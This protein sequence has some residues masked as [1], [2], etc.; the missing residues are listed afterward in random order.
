MNDANDKA[1]WTVPQLWEGGTCWIIGGGL[2]APRQFDVPEDIIMRVAVKRDL[3]P[4]AYSPY[5]QPIHNER[6]IAINNAYRIGTW[7]DA[8]F[9]G[10]CSWYLVHRRKL[11]DWPGIKATCCVRFANKRREEAE[12]IK[13]LGK[14]PGKKWGISDKPKKV[15]WNSNSGAAA[16]S[17]AAHLGVHRI[18]LLGFDMKLSDAGD[19]KVSHWHGSHRKPSE[20]QKAPPFNRHLKGFPQIKKD[21]KRMGIQILNASPDSVIKE[22]RKVRV[23]EVL[24]G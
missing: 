6:V 24:R 19:K 22:F 21:A 14:Y 20:K 4:S 8:L 3:D 17:L 18:I 23:S 5:F 11:I 7:I 16:I 2:S 12:G 13:Y 10:D 15:C 9:F 1:Q